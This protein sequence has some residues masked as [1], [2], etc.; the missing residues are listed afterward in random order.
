MPTVDTQR[1][2]QFVRDPSLQH[3]ELRYSQYSMPVFH[4]HNHDAYSIG[5]VTQGSTQF[6][7]VLEEVSAIP[8]TCGDLVLI[9]PGEVHACNP[10]NGSPFSYYMLYIQPDYVSRLLAEVTD[11]AIQPYRFPV[12]LIKDAVI[13]RKFEEMCRSMLAGDSR[14]EIESEIHEVIISIVE[15]C[16]RSPGPEQAY[17]TSPE[18]IQTGYRY[19]QEHLAENISL[20][21]LAGLCALSPFHFLRSF[22]RQ[23][24]LP[25]HTC[26]LQMRINHARQ[27]LVS[28]RSIAETAAE[29]GFADQSHFSR[30]F[31]SL[32]GATPR[33]YQSGVA[34]HAI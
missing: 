20:Q 16:S 13:R 27:L 8:V 33:Q 25:P 23:Y 11:Q 28:G 9:N 7:L 22:R 10:E 5:L 17:S 3:I 18:A 24:G 19:L 1:I 2:V 4:R 29:V 12:P 15:K 32:V 30:K 14:L 6:H 34:D 26:Q 31:R 21:E